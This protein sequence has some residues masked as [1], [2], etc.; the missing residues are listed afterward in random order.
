M[1]KTY[2]LLSIRASKAS[3]CYRQDVTVTSRNRKL[4]GRDQACFIFTLIYLTQLAPIKTNETQK[5]CLQ[6]FSIVYLHC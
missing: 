6:K 5:M 4:G 2:A 3:N 1:C